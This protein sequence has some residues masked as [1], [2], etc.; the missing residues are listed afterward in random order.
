MSVYPRKKN[1]HE[2]FIL[3][4]SFFATIY[5]IIDLRLKNSSVN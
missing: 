2:Y 1:L 5:D 4:V 3:E